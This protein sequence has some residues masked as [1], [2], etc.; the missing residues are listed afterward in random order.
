M[1]PATHCHRGE[2]GLSE[3][4]GAGDEGGDGAAVQVVSGVGDEKIESQT[5]TCKD[6]QTPHTRLLIPDNCITSMYL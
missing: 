6:D 3:E 1:V 4:A 2:E 5:N